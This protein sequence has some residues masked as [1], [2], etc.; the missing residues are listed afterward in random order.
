[1]EYNYKDRSS[2]FDLFAL[3]LIE[4]YKSQGL[5]KELI[6]NTLRDRV[7]DSRWHIDKMS[8]LVDS[9]SI[10]NFRYAKL[11][12]SIWLQ[13]LNELEANQRFIVMQY[14]KLN[15]GRLIEKHLK[16]LRGYEEMQYRLRDKPDI[17]AVEGICNNPKCKHLCPLKMNLIDYFKIEKSPYTLSGMTC[18]WCGLSGTLSISLPHF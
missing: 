7:N 1:M 16:Y 11:F 15:I 10:P 2:S 6:V 9:L 18:P 8:D 14:V 4:K 3:T 12:Y 13:T 17:L 5:F